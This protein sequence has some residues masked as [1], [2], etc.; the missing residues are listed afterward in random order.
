MDMN[1]GR[2]TVRMPT[3]QPQS[4]TF[5]KFFDLIRYEAFNFLPS[6]EQLIKK[7]ILGA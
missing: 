4:F 3:Y 1:T 5:S 6:L 7:Q 2:V